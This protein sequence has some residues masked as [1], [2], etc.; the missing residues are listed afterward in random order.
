MKPVV[1]LASLVLLAG[2]GMLHVKDQASV[3]HVP[4]SKYRFDY[5][6]S[7]AEPISLLRVFD[8]GGSSYLQFRNSVPDGLVV[9]AETA[10]GEAVIPHERMGNYAILRGVYRELSIPPATQPVVAR[11][12]GDIP[13]M[14]NLGPVVIPKVIGETTAAIKQETEGASKAEASVPPIETYEI[15]FARNSAALGPRGRREMKSL[16]AAH[17][18]K[19]EVEIKVRPFYPN[20]R[21]SVRLAKARAESIRRALIARGVTTANIRIDLERGAHPLVAEVSL[22]STGDPIKLSHGGTLQ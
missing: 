15:H 20:R 2:C 21:A 11:K 7:N 8:D 5:T 3:T 10:N 18:E 9:S 12:L 4:Q 22:H 1:W 16:V 14:T 6:L 13:P 19:S 17:T